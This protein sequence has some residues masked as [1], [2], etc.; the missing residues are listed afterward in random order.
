LRSPSGDPS[1]YGMVD[2]LAILNCRPRGAGCS[3]GGAKVGELDGVAGGEIMPGMTR[4]E[5]GSRVAYSFHPNSDDQTFGYT[6]RFQA[7][8]TS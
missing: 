8:V 2:G 5:Q 3:G 7:A 1:P 4:R 6:S